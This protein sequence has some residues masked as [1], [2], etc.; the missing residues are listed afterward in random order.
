M[1]RLQQDGIAKLA[2]N[3]TDDE[4]I[5][6]ASI[7]KINWPFSLPTVG[8]GDVA[9]ASLRGL[10]SLAVRDLA[11]PIG[12]ELSIDDEVGGLIAAMSLGNSYAV[13]YVAMNSNPMVLVG[14][15]TYLWGDE[16]VVVD[17]LTAGGIHSLIS[18]DRATGV[19]IL[20]A[21]VENVFRLGYRDAAAGSNDAGL[22]SLSSRDGGKTVLRA[23]QG[24]LDFG[25]FD[26]DPTSETA[27]FV[28]DDSTS[29]FE[30]SGVAA[31]F[32]E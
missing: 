26:H 7:L 21:T 9:A 25:H 10:R 15:S 4:V 17:M 16:V 20:V 27:S 5:A 29:V 13:S 31:I 28:V 19:E 3:L 6:V 2:L 8:S 23:S 30:I 32:S 12:E 1:S 22:Y 11:T 14:T 24:R 18:T